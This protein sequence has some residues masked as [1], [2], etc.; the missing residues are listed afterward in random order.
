[1]HTWS[2]MK[3]T[4]RP[5]RKGDGKGVIECF[6]EGTRSGLNKYTGSDVLGTQAD[7]KAFDKEYSLHRRN[8]F[9]FVAVDEN[10]HK[11]VGACLFY[12][13]AEGRT[14]HRG[15]VGCGV[16]P[17]YTRRHIGSR[18]LK[19]TIDMAARN[20]FERV[21][22]EVAAGNT[23]SLKLAKHCGFKLEGTK[24]KGL[25][26]DDGKYVNVYVFGKLIG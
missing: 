8:L 26:L 23:A 17:D 5:V 4:I 16:H 10:H 14:R 2:P 6:N 13:K 9:G 3:I 24:K 1:M 22:A 25:L 20:G 21:E 7:I 11:I 12:A 15:E 18:L 19:A